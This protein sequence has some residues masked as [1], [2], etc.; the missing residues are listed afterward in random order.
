[1]IRP[2]DGSASLLAPAA[3]YR[4]MDQTRKPKGTR[5]GGQ[6]A[7]D[8]KTESNQVLDM[9][10]TEP[11]ADLP[12]A[13]YRHPNGGGWVKETATAD[14]GALVKPH[15]VV[16]DKASIGED[17]VILERARI[18]HHTI[19]QRLSLIGGALKLDQSVR[20]EKDHW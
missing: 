7:A 3:L 10:G 18:G 12:V 17:V 1:M 2:S 16:G 19:V 6:F 4:S 11:T 14:P 13:A 8:A 5:A 9:E 15:A 20:L